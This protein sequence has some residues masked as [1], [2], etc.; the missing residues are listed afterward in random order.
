MFFGCSGVHCLKP[1]NRKLIQTYLN[2]SNL[3]SK[4]YCYTESHDPILISVALNTEVVFTVR[5]LGGMKVT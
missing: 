5:M 2:K 3:F 4:I 1:L